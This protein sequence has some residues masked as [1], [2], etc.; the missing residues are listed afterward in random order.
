MVSGLLFELGEFTLGL[1]R[2][3]HCPSKQRQRG[4]SA[5][6]RLSA[7]YRRD[8]TAGKGWAHQPAW[9]KKAVLTLHLQNP[10]HRHCP[11]NHSGG[12]RQ[13]CHRSDVDRPPVGWENDQP[14]V[15]ISGSGD[16]TTRPSDVAGG[17][18]NQHPKEKR[19][20]LQT[21]KQPKQSQTK[22]LRYRFLNIRF[23]KQVNRYFRLPPAR[24]LPARP[25]PLNI[26]NEYTVR[27]KYTVSLH[28]CGGI[29][30]VLSSNAQSIMWRPYLV[31]T[32]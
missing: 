29:Y 26:R 9:A 2:Q 17:V 5:V 15:G 23:L 31:S 4:G 14:A 24:F 16:Q 11:P 28:M 18:S 32:T 1:S 27:F 20:T 21:T 7:K 6:P 12:L 25:D 19:T 13:A 10:P 30:L 8:T 22:V 3:R